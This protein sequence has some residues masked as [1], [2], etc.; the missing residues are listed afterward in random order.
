MKFFF[1]SILI[2]TD[3]SKNQTFRYKNRYSSP[4]QLRGL[5]G[6]RPTMDFFWKSHKLI[7]G[8]TWKIPEA[9][10]NPRFFS[11][12]I[13]I[14]GLKIGW[15]KVHWKSLSVCLKKNSSNFISDGL[16]LLVWV[17]HKKF[18]LD[19][20]IRKLLIFKPRA[21]VKSNAL[22]NQWSFTFDF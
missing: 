3:K 17:T 22:N 6:C 11:K 1:Q 13:H 15:K 14:K 12:A 7:L 9:W 19:R 4:S 10:N 21:N 20:W 16:K 18:E 5:G 8:K 2:Q